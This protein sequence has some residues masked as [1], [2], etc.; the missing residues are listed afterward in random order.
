[1]PPSCFTFLCQWSVVSRRSQESGVRSQESGV[2]RKKSERINKKS[3]F[4]FLFLFLS[5]S[6]YDFYDF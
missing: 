2:R 1:M 6:S 5:L 4:R 3:P